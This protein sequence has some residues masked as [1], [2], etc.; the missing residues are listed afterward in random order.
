MAIFKNQS[1]RQLESLI[2][3]CLQGPVQAVCSPATGAI[4]QKLAT[5]EGAPDIIMSV[6]QGWWPNSSNQ[7]SANATSQMS[8]GMS[9]MANGTSQMANGTSQMAVGMLHMV[10]GTSQMTNGTS[11]MANGT[12]Q[13]TKA[14]TTIANDK[15][16]T[17]SQMVTT[18]TVMATTTKK[19]SICRFSVGIIQ[20]FFCFVFFSIH[21]A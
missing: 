4:V 12:S 1:C 14:A 20:L 8:N 18:T 21:F 10:N 17:N 7:T 11:Q 2:L 9:Q 16:S 13:T 19:G 15:S 6:C 3:G 5:L